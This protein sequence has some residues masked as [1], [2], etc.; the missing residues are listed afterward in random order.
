MLS[1]R[2]EAN[3]LI[4]L[5]FCLAFTNRAFV[6]ALGQ[7]DRLIL[8]K[9]FASAS[10][11]LNDMMASP[12]GGI[13]K[14]ILMQAKCVTVI[15]ASKKSAFV[16][17]AQYGRGVATCRTPNG[18]SAPVFVKLEGD[19]FGFQIG[20]QSTDLVL[21][22]MNQNGLQDMLKNK[23]KLGADAAASAGPVGRNVQA[24]KDWARNSEFLTYSRSKGL[25]AGFA[26]DGAVLSK[27]DD[28]TRVEYNSTLSSASILKGNQP[29]PQDASSFVGTVTHWF[30]GSPSKGSSREPDYQVVKIFYATDRSKEKKSEGILQD[31]SG[32]RANSEDLTFGQAEISIPRDH[33]MGEIERPSLLRLEMRE[34]PEK[35]IVMLK[36]TV[37]NE[38]SFRAAVDTRLRQGNGR[39]VLI[40]V[41]G[42]RVTFQE[43]AQRL[44][45]MTYDLGFGGAPILYSWPSAGELAD[46]GADEASAE[47]SNRHF[48]AFIEKLAH[49][50]EIKNI[51]V[52]AHS[53][54]NRIVASALEQI[55][56][57]PEQSRPAIH[58]VIMAA[59]DIDEGAFQQIASAVRLGASRITI[60]ESSNDKALEVSHK[61]HGYSRLGD[62]SPTMHVFSNYECIEA[63][64]LETDFVGHSYFG[65]SRSILSDIYYILDDGLPAS[66]RHGLIQKQLGG[67]PYWSFRP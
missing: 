63:S 48:L 30:S 22:A 41:H 13:P 8:A 50:P 61:Y 2:A 52:I 36:S 65:D 43:A 38:A 3:R 66:Q 62:T 21:I 46:Y 40:F 55:A 57:E 5:L 24:E 58:D 20:G 33:K 64:A 59:P 37:L 31:F 7:E 1:R 14:N 47:W 54:G 49:D 35:H 42:Y 6:C 23:V 12:D 26:L 16:I 29:V 18:W 4:Y 10:A 44:G 28:D 39:D 15:P 9:D 53:M 25:F 67:L 51:Y 60:Y 34:D 56:L 32:A 19:S 17:G 45:Q 27:N 11:V